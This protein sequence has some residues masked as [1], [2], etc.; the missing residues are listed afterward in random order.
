MSDSATQVLRE[1]RCCSTTREASNRSNK[2]SLAWRPWPFAVW[3]DPVACC[4]PKPPVRIH[5]PRKVDNRLRMI[6]A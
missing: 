5:Q 6:T 4:L 2:F 3:L 1:I